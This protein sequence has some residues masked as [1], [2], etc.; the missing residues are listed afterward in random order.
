[1]TR[2]IQ[3]SPLGQR[4]DLFRVNK[5]P[6]IYNPPCLFSASA[7]FSFRRS[8]IFLRFGVSY[9]S[10]SFIKW[11]IF[12]T[13]GAIFLKRGNMMQKRVF[14]RSKSEKSRAEGARIFLVQIGQLYIIP[15]L[16]LSHFQQGGDYLFGIGLIHLKHT[17]IS[18]TGQNP[19]FSRNSGCFNLSAAGF[20]K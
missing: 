4:S 18:E 12:R 3:Q 17:G 20:L 1:M 10:I 7:I 14:N 19:K 11:M 9:W 15:P 2:P 13:C 5:P 8:R 16:V 6:I